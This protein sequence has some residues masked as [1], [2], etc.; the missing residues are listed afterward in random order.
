V[1]V[2][3]DGR[4]LEAAATMYPHAPARAVLLLAD[5]AL[6]RLST[7]WVRRATVLGALAR[8]AASQEAGDD[9]T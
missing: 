6:N 3:A 5:A 2:A 9:L 8:Q 7:P 4:L 1:L